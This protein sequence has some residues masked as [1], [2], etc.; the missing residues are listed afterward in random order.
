[1]PPPLGRVQVPVENVEL[2]MG[3]VHEGSEVELRPVKVTRVAVTVPLYD[4]PLVVHDITTVHDDCKMSHVSE[5]PHVPLID[6]EPPM[7]AQV[8][9]PLP[10]PPPLVVSPPVVPLP[11]VPVPVPVPFDEVEHAL[12]NKSTPTI[13]PQ[14]PV[15]SMARSLPP[16]RRD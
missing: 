10:L 9:V 5:G 8:L 4:A 1:M 12:D 7:F 13:A 14:P 3:A 2:V 16:R 11:P 15:A 6:H